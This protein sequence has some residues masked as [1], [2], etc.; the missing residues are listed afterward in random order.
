M[1]GP[2]AGCGGSDCCGAR[3]TGDPGNGF[4]I[5]TC[6]GRHTDTRK[7]RNRFRAK[8]LAGATQGKPQRL[9]HHRFRRRPGNCD[10][11]QCHLLASAY[12]QS[13]T[14]RRCHASDP[15]RSAAGGSTVDCR[16]ASGGA[17]KRSERHNAGGRRRRRYHHRTFNRIR[18]AGDRPAL[19]H[20]VP[21]RVDPR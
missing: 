7:C 3:R 16:A 19:R 17:G 8:I 15:C 4:R 14:G 9:D 13:R 11:R 18:D 2:S 12:P 1:V 20:V 5:R 6:V 10:R 21:G